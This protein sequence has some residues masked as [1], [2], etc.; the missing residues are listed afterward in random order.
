M[1]V[2]GTLMVTSAPLASTKILPPLKKVLLDLHQLAPEG[3]LDTEAALDS[4]PGGKPYSTPQSGCL[5]RLYR[6]ASINGAESVGLKSVV[7][8]YHGKRCITS[9][10]SEPILA[11]RH[12]LVP[13]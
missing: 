2:V 10:I 12:K 13:C 6:E 3:R 11:N 8:L 4:K 1:I 7:S 9:L 5:A